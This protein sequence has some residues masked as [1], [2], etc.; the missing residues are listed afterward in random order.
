MC[1]LGARQRCASILTS[2]Q[3]SL[4]TAGSFQ[5]QSVPHMMTSSIFRVNHQ[6]KRRNWIRGVV[7]GHNLWWLHH[8]SRTLLPASRLLSC[9]DAFLWYAAGGGQTRYSTVGSVLA[10]HAGRL[11]FP[12][13]AAAAAAAEVGL[14]VGV[15]DVVLL[16]SPQKQDQRGSEQ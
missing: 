4:P 5:F 13:R 15:G 16:L 12:P 14:A 8:C 1:L 10:G 7:T 11:S 9:C 6:K 3:P 2:Q